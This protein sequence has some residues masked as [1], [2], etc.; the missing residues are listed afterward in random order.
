MARPRRS[1]LEFGIMAFICVYVLAGLA[2]CGGVAWLIFY[3]AV[4][5]IQNKVIP[6]I[7]G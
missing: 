6:W 3:V 2:I 7:N 1:L 5:F 4:P